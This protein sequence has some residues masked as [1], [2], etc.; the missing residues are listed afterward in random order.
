MST[1]IYK[2]ITIVLCQDDFEN[3][4]T[5]KVFTDEKLAKDYYNELVD[6]AKDSDFDLEDYTIDEDETSFE[7]YLTGYASEDSLSIYIEEDE[8]CEELEQSNNMEKDYDI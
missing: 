6:G 8:I 7:R 1:K 5:V 4:V 2:V 3:T